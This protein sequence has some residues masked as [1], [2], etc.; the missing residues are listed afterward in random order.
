MG[1]C[2]SGHEEAKNTLL[3]PPQ[4]GCDIDVLIKRQGFLG[5]DAD[6]DVFDTSEMDEKGKPLKKIWMLLDAVGG[7]SDSEYDYYLKYRAEGMEQSRILGCAEM[8]K[9]YDYMWFRVTSSH[10]TSGTH[11]NTGDRRNRRWIDKHVTGDWVICRRGRMYGPPKNEEAAYEKKK[12]SE[13]LLDNLI[14]RIQLTGAGGY[15]RTYH[16][17]DWEQKVVR[18]DKDG[19][20]TVSWEHRTSVADH[21]STYLKEFQYKM[22]SYGTD[23][24]IQYLK[25]EGGW[26]KSDKHQFVATRSSDGLPLFSVESNGSS[27][28]TLKTFSNSD[29]VS[30]LIM[31]FAISVKM[32]PPEFHKL[33]HS[34]CLDKIGLD[35]QPGHF[36]GFGETETQYIQMFPTPGELPPAGYAYGV[37]QAQYPPTAIVPVPPAQPM[38]VVTTQ[39]TVITQTF[40]HTEVVAI[41][42][43]VVGQDAEGNP[44]QMM[45]VNYAYRTTTTTQQVA[46]TTMTAT[47]TDGY[48]NQVV[49]QQQMQQVT[50]AQQQQIAPMQPAPETQIA[51]AKNYAQVAP[52]PPEPA[53][54]GSPPPPE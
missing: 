35:L 10:Q 37:P 9:E 29:P 19:N 39:Q 30:A 43:P 41:Q 33:C 46:T 22:T 20:K 49:Q 47:T 48:G 2:C 27:T 45:Q 52:A 32:E 17:E 7:F 28:A 38:T 8:K 42:T 21:P 16:R 26:L 18:E 40:T 54:P 44:V 36:G 24:D 51:Y 6:F 14:G 25:K 53:P 31:S 12:K 15:H 13:D 11:P 3:A 1:C 5:F 50:Q 34:Y 4:F 23:Y